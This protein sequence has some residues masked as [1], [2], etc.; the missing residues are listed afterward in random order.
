MVAAF[1]TIGAST[2]ASIDQSIDQFIGADVIVTSNNFSSFSGDVAKRVAEV[3]GVRAVSPLRFVKG[4]IDGKSKSLVSIDP[5]TAA[6]AFKLNMRG[7]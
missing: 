7:R 3:D 2:T 1:G 4:K 6:E 5:A